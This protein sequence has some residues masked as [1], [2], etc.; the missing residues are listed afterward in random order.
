MSNHLF[1]DPVVLLQDLP[2]LIAK[3]IKDKKDRA[4]D[5]SLMLCIKDSSPTNSTYPWLINNPKARFKFT[6]CIGNSMA[7]LS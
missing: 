1:G 3:D 2:N 6:H 4:T 5:C 7:C